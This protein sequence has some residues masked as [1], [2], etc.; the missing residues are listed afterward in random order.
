VPHAPQLSPSVS[1]SLHAPPQIRPEG[2]PHTPDEHV[3]PLA[4]LLLQEPQFCTSDCVSV[5]FPPHTEFPAG[6]E[7][8]E[9]AQAAPVAQTFP[10]APQC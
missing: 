2:Q 5:H 4:H 10:H 3:N 6:H 1:G 9:H 7:Q 8:T